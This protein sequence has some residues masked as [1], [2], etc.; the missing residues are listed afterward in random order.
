MNLDSSYNITWLK[1]QNGFHA[2]ELRGVDVE[3]LVAVV[4]QGEVVEEGH[5]LGRND[6]VLRYG[7]E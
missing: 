7:K 3:P 2:G 1:E 6:L 4:H 5:R